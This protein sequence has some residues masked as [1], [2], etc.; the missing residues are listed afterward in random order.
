MQEAGIIKPPELV[1]TVEEKIQAVKDH[2]LQPDA[3][4]E[5]PLPC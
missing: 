5:L 3:T 4:E 1:G 2:N